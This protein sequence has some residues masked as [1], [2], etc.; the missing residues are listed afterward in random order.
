L[1]ISP[2]DLSWGCPVVV[3]QALAEIL[4]FYFSLNNKSVG[5]FGYTPHLG[6]PGLIEQMKDLAERQS[7]HR[8]KHLIVTCGATGA[9]N[10]ALYALK[11][12]DEKEFVLINKRHFPFYPDM[13]TV[14]GLIQTHDPSNGKN[15]ISLIDSPSAPEGLVFPFE[16]VDIWDSAYAS[17]TYGSGGHTPTKWR[18]MCGSLSKTLGVSGLRLGWASTDSDDLA[19][20]IGRYVS[21]AYIG[22]PCLSMD[23]AEAVLSRLDLSRFELRSSGYIDDNRHE[24]QR[25]F[26]KFGQGQVPTRGMFAILQLGRSERK[27]LEKAGIKWQPGSTWGEDDT[28]ARLSLGQSREVVRMSVK[29]ALR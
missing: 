1:N 7:G 20:R 26:N 10:A 27:A 17:R 16:S 8:P 29:G 28:W 25:L 14:A 3:R 5:S 18:I 11:I 22:L 12:E 4:G 9:I 23:T 2:N 24:I 15:T 19:V 13:I 6:S 21:A